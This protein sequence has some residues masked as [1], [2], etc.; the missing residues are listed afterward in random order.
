L[1]APVLF[2]VPHVSDGFDGI[3]AFTVAI[4]FTVA[5]GTAIPIL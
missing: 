5:V 2:L 4:A 3:A 1:K